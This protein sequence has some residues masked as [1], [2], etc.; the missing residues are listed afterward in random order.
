ML[1]KIDQYRLRLYRVNDC[2]NLDL[3]PFGILEPQPSL[4]FL[5]DPL[6]VSIA[7]IPGL[8]FDMQTKLRLGYG[9]GFYDRLLGEL[10]H[11]Q[12]YGIAFLEQSVDNLAYDSYDIPM[13][14]IMLF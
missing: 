4:A 3:H 12:T 2:E 1:P 8:G 10:D 5:F 7:F 13:K 14:H 6:L 9:K 11:A